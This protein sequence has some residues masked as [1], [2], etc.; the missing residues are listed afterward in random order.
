[1]IINNHHGKARSND[2]MVTHSAPFLSVKYPARGEA[3]RCAF[4]RHLRINKFQGL[5]LQN[6]VGTTATMKTSP[7]VL[8]SRF[9]ISC[10]CKGMVGS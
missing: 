4:R 8:E 1:M 9:Q 5:N 3:E 2:K 7:T 10:K 6:R